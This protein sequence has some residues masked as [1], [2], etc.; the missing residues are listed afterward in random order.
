MT[1]IKKRKPQKRCTMADAI[2]AIE[3]IASITERIYRTIKPIITAVIA[4]GRRTK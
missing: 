4:Y 2:D 1:D 3:D